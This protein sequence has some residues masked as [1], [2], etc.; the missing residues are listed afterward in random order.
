MF[1]VLSAFLLYNPE[2]G[3]YAVYY[4]KFGIGFMRISPESFFWYVLPIICV[5]FILLVRLREKLSTAYL[6]T[7]LLVVLSAV[8]NLVYFFGRSH[9]HALLNIA[10]ILLFVV[11]FLLDLVVRLLRLGFEDGT[12]PVPPL[13]YGGVS[14]AG[15]LLAM[16]VVYY[17]DNISTK[18]VRQVS[19]VAQG[20]VTYPFEVDRS[21]LEGE[22][23][24]IRRATE[25][26]EK[27]YFLSRW[28]F[29]YY[30]YG[31]Y[32]PLGYVNPFWAWIVA[33]PLRE[34]LNRLLDN[35][36]FLVVSDEMRPVLEYLSIDYDFSTDALDLLVISRQAAPVP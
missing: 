32:R 12:T 18:A 2:F 10:I 36:Y 24:A 35:G 20:D 9:E 23:Q 11:F 21:T 6:Q 22:L 31:G 7:A 34:Q 27:I 5:T 33:E 8:A 16:M 13:R 29:Q 26:S 28:D 4:Q 15:L 19:A 3:N 14:V 25:K 1:G 17:G 30:Y